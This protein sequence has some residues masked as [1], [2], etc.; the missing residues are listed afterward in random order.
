MR[1]YFH[2]FFSCQRHLITE[3]GKVVLT[4][5]QENRIIYLTGKKFI[6]FGTVAIVQLTL[7]Y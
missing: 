6:T 4:T 3:N 7:K 2:V 5:D 1:H